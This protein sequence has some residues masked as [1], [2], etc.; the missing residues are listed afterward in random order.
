MAILE[1]D[2]VC[3]TYGKGATATHAVDDVS[4]S[5]REGE[6]ALLTGPSGAGKSTILKLILAMERPERGTIRVAGRDVHRLMDGS[7]PFLRRNLGVVFQDFKLLMEATAQE[8]VAIALQVLGLPFREVSRRAKDALG[9]VNLGG[10]AHKQVRLLSGGEQQRVALAR[11]LAVEPSLLLADE[12]TGNLDPDLTREI[13]HELASIRDRGTTILL[14]THDPLVMD[15]ASAD[16]RICILRGRISEDHQWFPAPV[17]D[18]DGAEG[19]ASSA[20]GVGYPYD[21]GHDAALPRRRVDSRLDA[22]EAAQ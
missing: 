5:L 19:E 9:R 4:F 7:I 14:A 6:L 16:R 1:F 10:L 13:L 22:L 17:Y 18:H 3:K 2:G 8:N 20:H 21:L 15:A 12:P 11:A